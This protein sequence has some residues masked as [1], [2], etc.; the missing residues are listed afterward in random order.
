LSAHSDDLGSYDTD[1]RARPAAH[2]ARRR[3]RDV[4]RRRHP[5]SPPL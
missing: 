2:A 5:H 3:A 4:R 1:S